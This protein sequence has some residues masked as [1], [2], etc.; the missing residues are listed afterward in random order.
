M[1]ESWT[2]GGERKKSLFI[3]FILGDNKHPLR[4]I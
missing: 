4:V 2:R 3:S 1:G